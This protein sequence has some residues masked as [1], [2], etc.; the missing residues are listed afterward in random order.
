MT[1]CQSSRAAHELI[2]RAASQWALNSPSGYRAAASTWP[3]VIHLSI[4]TV[5]TVSLLHRPCWGKRIRPPASRQ[6]AALEQ[7][8]TEAQQSC[9]QVGGWLL[10]Q[11]DCPSREEPPSFGEINLLVKC[12]AAH[13]GVSEA[14]L[15][16]SKY[17]FYHTEIM[18]FFL[19]IFLKW[20]Y[21]SS[22]W[23]G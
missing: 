11:A 6:K 14:L 3:S 8:D 20:I 17:E 10:P 15:K 4:S 16:V 5:L 18:N 12:K 21:Q 7:W 23:C 9:P 2:L 19:S 22:A 13:E 1:W